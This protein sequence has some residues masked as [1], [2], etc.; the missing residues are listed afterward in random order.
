[1]LKLDD[2]SGYGVQADTREFWS[3]DRYVHIKE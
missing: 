1:M 2:A 3:R